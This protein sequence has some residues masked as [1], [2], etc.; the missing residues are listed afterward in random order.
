MVMMGILVMVAIVN[1]YMLLTTGV[2]AIFMYGMTLVYLSTAQAIKRLEG[3]SRSPVFSHVTATMSGLGTV[4][5]CE[6]EEL[7]KIQ[8]DDK[9]DVHT[10][11]W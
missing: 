2:C 10:A 6:A 8:F 11:A 3:V 4:R 1:P 7:L 9:Q 5:A